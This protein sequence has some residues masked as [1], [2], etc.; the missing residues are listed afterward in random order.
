MAEYNFAPL[1][2]NPGRVKISC[3][4]ISFPGVGKTLSGLKLA[5][6]IAGLTGR[7]IVF[8][9]DGGRSNEYANYDD[10][11]IYDVAPIEPPYLVDK[12]ISAIDYAEANGYDVAVFDSISDQWNGTGGVLDAHAKIEGE[13]LKKNPNWKNAGMMAWRKVKADQDRFVEKSRNSKVHM[14]YTA[15]VKEGPDVFGDSKERNNPKNKKLLQKAG[16]IS[17]TKRQVVLTAQIDKNAL[18]RQVVVSALL[19][20]EYDQNGQIVDR[21]PR[22]FFD[23]LPG[24]LSHVLKDGD[25]ISVKT[26]RDIIDSKKQ[27]SDKEPDI[28][29]PKLLKEAEEAAKSG[30]YAD[31]WEGKSNKIRKHLTDSGDHERFK[32]I[33][34]DVE[35]AEVMAETPDDL[36]LY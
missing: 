8:D 19:Y 20:N 5:R 3:C 11:G 10:V 30:K 32:A 28:D 27:K 18:Y 29:F 7:I 17:D 4:L 24:T 2:A 1:P 12:F 25:P 31:W 26:G 22:A 16:V 23:K 15:Y 14:I 33:K 35:K 6:G 9:T 34:P 21:V 13:I 36:E